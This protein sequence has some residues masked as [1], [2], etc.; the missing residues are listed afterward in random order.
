P[1]ALS[2]N[3]CLQCHQSIKANL[4]AHT[5]HSADSVGS[6]CYDC[7]M[8]HTSFGLMRATRSHQISV[9]T[10]KESVNVG[11]PN[12]CNLCHL[13]KPLSWT[14]EKLHAWYGQPVPDLSS[15]DKEIATGVKWLVTG[16]AGMRALVS[17]SMGW[18][19]AQKASG[20]D[21]L[22]PYL[23][24]TLIDP[25]AAVRFVAGK[26]LQTLSPYKNFKFVYTASRPETK[27]LTAKTY[28]EW[29]ELQRGK[30]LNFSSATLIDSSGRIKPE[31][32]QRLLL[33]R[34]NRMVFLI[35]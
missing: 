29:L 27:A 30:I 25:Y 6:R 11:R 35:E 1:D 14:A 8:P 21:W 15:D 10:V 17:W 34:D 16:D 28:Q 7:H 24:V 12:A 33:R 22:A 5:H 3:A 13:D 32:Y 20:S 26:S 31:P 2:D 18:A 4:S 9:P 23:I 19:P